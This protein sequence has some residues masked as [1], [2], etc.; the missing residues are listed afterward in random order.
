MTDFDTMLRDAL[1]T[2][3]ERAPSMPPQWAGPTTATI[4]PI[5]RRR[6][7]RRIAVTAAGIAAAA[8][9]VTVL[10]LV[11]RPDDP[12]VRV[13]ATE[14]IPTPW[15]P[16]GTEFPLTDLGP[17]TESQGGPVV[18]ALTR[19]VG[20]PGYPER[21]VAP[22]LAYHGGPTAEVEYC[23]WSDRGGACRP[24]WY[25]TSWSFSDDAD[26]AGALFTFDGL[27]AGTAFA[28]Y[29][30]GETE[31]WQRPVFGF[32]AFP[33]LPGTAE[34]VT[35]WDADG[36]LIGTYGP[37]AIPDA[38]GTVE[39]PAPVVASQGDVQEFF[40]LTW[41]SMAA[42]LTEHGGALSEGDVA[43]FPDGVDQVAVWTDCVVNVKAIVAQAV[44]ALT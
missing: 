18:A 30:D 8:A 26:A 31:H 37:G 34:V 32:A 15:Q 4:I 7:G 38:E 28:G 39:L 25:P 35:A 29:S 41:S 17:A 20:A 6:P 5:E 11:A 42:C 12:T 19:R 9:A 27:P 1:T 40:S 22:S 23:V 33:N 10:A 14:P 3:A 2:D 16:P 44:A 21:I 36:T 24:E 43:T 13:P